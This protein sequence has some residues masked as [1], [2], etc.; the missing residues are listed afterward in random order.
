MY[1]NSSLFWNPQTSLAFMIEYDTRHSGHF[2]FMISNISCAVFCV[3]PLGNLTKKYGV[4]A[5][6]THT[7]L[8]S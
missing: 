8:P 2:L 1:A 7:D 6:V 5:V 3:A 4:N